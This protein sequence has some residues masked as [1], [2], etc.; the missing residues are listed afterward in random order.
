MLNTGPI[1]LGQQSNPLSNQFENTIFMRLMSHFNTGNPFIDPI[2]NMF[3][4]SMVGM[5]VLNLKTILN[6]ANISYYLSY[7]TNPIYIVYQKIFRRDPNTIDKQVTI[8]GITDN[9]KVN[10]LYKAVD[11]Y[12][13]TK[14]EQDLTQETPLKMVFEDDIDLVNL[15]AKVSKKIVQNKYKNLV[16]KG[17]EIFYLLNKNLIT[18]Y[19]D[20]E[21]TRENFSITLSAKV[22][23][24]SKTCI[25]EE[26]CQHCL[27]EYIRSK[28]PDRWV[29]Q[30]YVNNS[31]GEWKSQPSHNKRKIDTVILKEGQLEDIKKD[32]TDFLDSEEWYHDRDIPYTRGYLLYGQPGTGKTS[33]IKAISTL[34]QRH[35]HYLMLNN[36]QDDTMLLDLL[37][38]IDYAKT[39]LTIEDIDCM[40]KIIEDRNKKEDV[41][42]YKK[43]DKKDKKDKEDKN[44]NQLTL[45][46]LLNALDG[47]FNNNGR[48]LVMTTNHP[49]V[50]DEALIRPGRI[51]RK[52]L[53]SYCDKYQIKGIFNM[54]YSDIKELDYSELDKIEE[55]K[56]S[57]ADITS[58]FLRYRNEPVKALNNL[59]ELEDNKLVKNSDRKFFGKDIEKLL[60]IEPVKNVTN[61]MA[62]NQ[63]YTMSEPSQPMGYSQPL[64]NN[65]WTSVP[66]QKI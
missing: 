39:I 60:K 9:R 43:K 8:D 33:F 35:M 41:E 59:H 52:L 54:M 14:C 65:E 51:D 53:F 58:L 5:V 16:Y 1:N 27:D 24:E 55:H 4:Y 38:K 3:I 42:V 40:T 15:G 45:S 57:P 61:T 13:S 63:F 21:R 48:I 18:V 49:E 23:K 17:H 6:L 47:I 32:V 50:L 29:Q 64:N 22:L 2:I 11:W 62:Q 20:K 66:M 37:S 36:V 28:R 46:G 44:P 25:L 56:Y 34:T 7:I 26:F 10:N 19:A 31:Q 12:L 30:I